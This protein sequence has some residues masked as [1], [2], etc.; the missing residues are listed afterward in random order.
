MYDAYGNLIGSTL[1]GDGLYYTGE[2]YDADLAHYYL[3]SRYY[4]PSTGRFN[5]MDSFNGSNYDP[6][7]LHKYLYCHANPLNGI[8]PSGQGRL[9]ELVTVI[10][11]GM[12][13][14]NLYCDVRQA[15]MASAQRKY[16]EATGYY[17]W[18]AVD[19]MALSIPF[20]GPTL[21]AAGAAGETIQFM[22]QAG[23]HPSAVIGYVRA[24]AHIGEAITEDGVDLGGGG[25][26]GSGK[27]KGGTFMEDE[28][29]GAWYKFKFF[30][31]MA[32]KYQA[33]RNGKPI[34]WDYFYNGVRFDGFRN[35][36][37]LE[38]KYNWKSLVSKKTGEFYDFMK[39]IVEKQA[40][41]QFDATDNMKIIWEF[42]D[43][44]AADACRKLFE[45]LNIPI[46]VRY[47]PMGGS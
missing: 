41:R 26:G 12:N 17:G 21:N 7:S 11:I 13:I 16:A 9:A 39:F 32:E 42:S 1:T 2:M 34:G 25:G 29:P 24:Y 19:I 35:G 22:I 45:K 4:N 44:A 14:I 23:V 38:C 47:A 36:K 37:L 40:R 43:E 20:S 46:E 8:D 3:R 10:G 33:F 31:K 28:G 15:V 27:P 6:Q 5:Q 30:N 18:A